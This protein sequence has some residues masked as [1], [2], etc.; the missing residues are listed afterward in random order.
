MKLKNMQKRSKDECNDKEIH[1]ATFSRM[2]R[3][4]MFQIKFM[5]K[6]CIQC[7]TEFIIIDP[8]TKCMNC[9]YI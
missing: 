2:G 8:D 5:S 3:Q 9:I 7:D 1:S 6:K 4:H